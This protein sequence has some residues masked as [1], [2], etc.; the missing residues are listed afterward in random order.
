MPRVIDGLFSPRKLWS[1]LTIT[2]C[3]CQG[4]SIKKCQKMSQNVKVAVNS[5]G[6]TPGRARSM[7]WLEDPPPW[8]KPWLHPAYSLAYCFAFVIV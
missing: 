4:E 6:A 3:K 8:L 7:T 1:L 2:L 5:D